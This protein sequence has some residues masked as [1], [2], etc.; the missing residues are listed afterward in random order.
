MFRLPFNY[1][2]SREQ[3]GTKGTKDQNISLF[4]HSLP[5]AFVQKDRAGG[6]GGISVIGDVDREFLRRL[7]HIVDDR[8]DDPLVGLMNHEVCHL[9]LV[10]T[11]LVQEAFHTFGTCFDSELE[12]FAPFICI[13][14]SSSFFVM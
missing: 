3:T 10:D 4:E 5:V 13:G 8:V 9:A 7:T 14:T 6:R 1:G 2:R 11:Y 12:D